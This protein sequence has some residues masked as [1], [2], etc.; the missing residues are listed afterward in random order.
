M[1]FSPRSVTFDMLMNELF[2]N[3]LILNRL[4]MSVCE[5]STHFLC[6]F[7]DHFLYIE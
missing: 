1:Y 2:E 6:K 4:D 5:C 3:P 7:T